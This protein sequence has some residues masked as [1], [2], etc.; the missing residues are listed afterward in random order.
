V[1][2]AE[3][4]IKWTATLEALLQRK[5]P[6]DFDP[7]AVRQALY[8]PFQKQRLY[9][10]PR[11]I[12]RPGDVFD[13]FPDKAQPNIGFLVTGVSSHAPFSAIACDL[14]PDKHLLD[15]GQFFPRWR[16]EKAGVDG[17]F[18]FGEPNSAV[19]DGYRQ[20]DNITDSALTRFRAAY[21]GKVTK[22]DIFFYAYG[23]LHS[24][25]YRETYAADLKK[26]L[27]R[28]PLVTDP[29]PFVEAG[30]AL[31]DLHIGYESVRG[32]RSEAWT[33]RWTVIRT[34]TTGSRR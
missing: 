30:R 2:R 22:D 8:R 3:T 4:E 26:T 21:G 28:V 13:A 20:V 25:E 10:D 6:I 27:P 32:T 11:W 12:H 16:Y 24:P 19:V 14:P 23:L 34:R 29:W 31:A 7:A 33:R 17:S 5:I 15:T 18:D 1:T 9:A